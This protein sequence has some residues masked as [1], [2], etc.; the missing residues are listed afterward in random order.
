MEQTPSPT[1]EP[2]SDDEPYPESTSVESSLRVQSESAVTSEG[3]VF[4]I[5]NLPPHSNSSEFPLR[6][7]TTPILFSL[8]I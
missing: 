8:N 5:Q 6:T 4:H 3:R 7:R 2:S 1:L